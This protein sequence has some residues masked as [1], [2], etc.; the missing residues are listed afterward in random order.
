[1]TA[2]EPTP[3]PGSVDV[4][5][6][7]L[8]ALLKGAA[9][10]AAPAHDVPLLHTVHL[11]AGGGWLTVEATDRY[12]LARGVVAAN[13]SGTLEAVIPLDSVRILRSAL[14][15]SQG[16]TTI[17]VDPGMTGSTPGSLTARVRSSRLVQVE[18]YDPRVPYPD[19]TSLIP[20]ATTGAVDAAEPIT[21][22]CWQIRRA[23]QLAGKA[24]NTLLGQV[25]LHIIPT[26][27]V[28]PKRRRVR[29]TVRGK[30]DIDWLVVAMQPNVPARE[31]S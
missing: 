30:H 6:S 20:D 22:D 27:S 14:R 9:Q 8:R 10:F 17:T 16:Y 1:M 25:P 12:G 7:A 23:A 18:I 11:T 5:A 21:L 24:A 4:S 29:L 3:E 13:C 19:L 2:T 28:D 15:G 26:A 31:S